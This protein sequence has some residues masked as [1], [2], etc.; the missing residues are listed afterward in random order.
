MLTVIAN[1]AISQNWP[2]IY[3][4]S[5]HHTVRS[6]VEDYDNG[7]LIT[8]QT[9]QSSVPRWA[10]LKKTDINGEII[11]EKVFGSYSYLTFFNDLLKTSNNETILIGGTTKY[12]PDE[13]QD[14]LIIKLNSCGEV[15]WCTVLQSEI[16]SIGTR[17]VE[18]SDGNVIALLKYFGKDVSKFRISLVKLDENGIPLWIKNLAQVNSLIFNEEGYDLVKVNDSSYVVSGHCW[19]YPDGLKQYWIHSDEIGEQTWEYIWAEGNGTTDESVLYADGSTFTMGI[20]RELGNPYVPTLFRISQDGQQMGKSLILGDTIAG[21]EAKPLVLFNDSMFFSGI[22][23]RAIGSPHE[24]CNSE[25]I[26]F[27]TSGNIIQRKHLI[28]NELGPVCAIKTYDD[29]LLVASTCD[30]NA[31]FEVYLW[32]LNATLDFDTAYTFPIVYDSLC[33]DSINSGTFEYDCN[34]IVNINEI[35]SLNEYRSK[36]KAYPNPADNYFFVEKQK[37]IENKHHLLEIVDSLGKK[38]EPKS[39]DDQIIKIDCSTWPSG[40]YLLILKEDDKLIDTGKIII[41]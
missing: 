15:E 5:Q 13:Q 38:M 2:K 16:G 11:W 12:D 17:I 6:I 22:Q 23:W 35:P 39:F 7:Y 20:F 37:S 28:V 25:A 27:D 31:K 14:P 33:S 32:K 36:F 10:W 24:E 41:K 26:L 29:K 34:F 9:F 18:L 19:L 3:S 8:G 4:H 21:S 40:I 30:I 1:N